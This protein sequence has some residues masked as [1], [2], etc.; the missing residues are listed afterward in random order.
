MTATSPRER[1]LLALLILALI[2]ALAWL[3]IVRPI[4]D[5]FRE[6]QLERDSLLLSYARNERIIAQ[7]RGYRAALAG[8][9]RTAGDFAIEA[10]NPAAAAEALRERILVTARGAGVIKAS[11]SEVQAEAGMV[12][13]RADMEMTIGQLERFLKALQNGRPILVIRNLSVNADQASRSNQAEAMDVR[14]EVMAATT[15]NRGA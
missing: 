14:L 1:R 3:A 11:A 6:R 10:A 13:M 12:A 7:A 8:Q 5:G 4:R 15:V 2:V 9:R